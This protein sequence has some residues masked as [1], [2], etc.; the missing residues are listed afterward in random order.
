MSVKILCDLGWRAACT[1]GLIFCAFDGPT[2]PEFS[3]TSKLANVDI[4]PSSSEAP[5]TPHI[6]FLCFPQGAILHTYKYI[7]IYQPPNHLSDSPWLHIPSD[8]SPPVGVY[9][10]AIKN[11]KVY[12]PKSAPVKEKGRENEECREVPFFFLI[13]SCLPTS[14]CPRASSL[15]RAWSC[16]PQ[17][18]PER[19]NDFKHTK[20]FA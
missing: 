11:L 6:F 1:E 18:S 3:E 9:G 16:L 5:P 20:C 19:W 17:S 2:L 14:L 15:R 4:P 8:P 10:G 7:C 12:G 13:L